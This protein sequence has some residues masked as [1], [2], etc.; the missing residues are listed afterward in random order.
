MSNGVRRNL[1]ADRP[2][3]RRPST[4]HGC[5]YHAI[6][7]QFE[8][9]L[10]GERVP[11]DRHEEDH[12]DD[13]GRDGRPTQRPVPGYERRAHGDAHCHDRR[14][15]V[16]GNGRRK[17]TQRGGEQHER[18]VERP[19][20]RERATCRQTHS[21]APVSAGSARAKRTSARPQASAG[22]LVRS[23]SDA[24]S[25]WPRGSAAYRLCGCDSDSVTANTSDE[26]RGSQGRKAV[27]SPALPARLASRMLSRM[28][29]AAK[30]AERQARRIRMPSTCSAGG[31]SFGSDRPLH[32]PKLHAVAL[33]NLGRLDL[34]RLYVRDQ[35]VRGAASA[36]PPRAGS[37]RWPSPRSTGSGRIDGR[38]HRG[39]A[40][41]GFPS[42]PLR[43]EEAASQPAIT[44]SL[45]AYAA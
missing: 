11:P 25:P 14:S 5:N 42:R 31:Q 18:A 26:R 23:R 24:L 29:A 21:S 10:D 30:V 19:W 17:N 9:E 35:L 2:E 38:R 1:T 34:A 8:R 7:L 6:G 32:D 20:P 15:A 4:E 40:M 36:S 16:E 13:R 12:E 28:K 22:P 39:S 37:F 33:G 27:T 44:A 41:G 45:V 43:G 3:V